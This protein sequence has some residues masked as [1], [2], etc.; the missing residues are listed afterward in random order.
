MFLSKKKDQKNRKQP[1]VVK[2]EDLTPSFITVAG[3]PSGAGFSPARVH[4][5][6]RPHVNNVPIDSRRYH[7]SI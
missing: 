5:L 3:L 2:N 6:A 4:D 7:Q 1:E